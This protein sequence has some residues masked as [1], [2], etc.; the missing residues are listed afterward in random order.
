VLSCGLPHGILSRLHLFLPGLL[1]YLHTKELVELIRTQLLHTTRPTAT[2]E[3]TE[4]RSIE[5]EEDRDT[6]CESDKVSLLGEEE[7]S[8]F[9]DFKPRLEQDESWTS[10]AAMLRFHEER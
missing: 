7:T 1:H 3:Q 9:Q 6:D 5:V 4:P 8:K 10:P 2:Q